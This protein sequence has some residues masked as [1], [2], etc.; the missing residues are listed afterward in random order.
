MLIISAVV[1]L[2]V[3]MAGCGT[4]LAVLNSRSQSSTVGSTLPSPSPA[5]SP[6][7]IEQP[8]PTSPQ[9]SS[10]ESTSAVSVAV[11]SGWAATKN[12]PTI[13]VTNPAGDGSV[14]VSS[15]SQSPPQ[16]PQQMQQSADQ[17]LTNQFPDAKTC[18]NSKTTS[19]AVGGISGI[20]W[21][22]CFTVAS[23]GQSFAGAMTIFAGANADGS[24]GYAVVL[25]AL[26]SKMNAFITEA[27]PVL[28][29]IQWK[30][31]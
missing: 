1:G 29:S 22:Q 23:G 7:P 8:S 17:A 6:S 28:Q 14:G 10:T 11:P 4:A 16:S 27:K 25:F 24:I 9:G 12:D 19:G 30:L 26:A 5:G 2:V 21:E 18:P 3:V 15:G 31:H 20:W 13:T